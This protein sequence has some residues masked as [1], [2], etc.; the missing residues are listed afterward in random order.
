[1][2]VDPLFNN[3]IGRIKRK[4]LLAGRRQLTKKKR[5]I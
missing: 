5:F 1:M 4:E 3:G 2:Q